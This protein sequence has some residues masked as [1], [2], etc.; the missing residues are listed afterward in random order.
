MIPETANEKSVPD[1][2]AQEWVE[3][4]RVT[5][6]HG[7]DGTLFVSLYGEDPGNLLRAETLR[8]EGRPGSSQIS[9]LAAKAAGHQRDGRARVRVRAEGID[10]RELAEAWAGARVSIPE[11]ALEPLPEGEFYWRE[12]L[13]LRCL[14]LAGEELGTVEEI[15]PT[16]DVD[17]LVVRQA[18]RTRLI[19]A[20]AGL[21]VR[22]DREAGELWIDPPEGLLEDA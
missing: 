2:G 9:I 6:A 5:R 13:G 21:M 16:G 8:L 7:L 11:A 10:R 17:V 20:L 1:T 15:W 22:V 4:G 19:P 14:T 3:V 18:D 12:I